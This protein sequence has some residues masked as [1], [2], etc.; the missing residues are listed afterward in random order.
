[1][2]ADT[3][4]ALLIFLVLFAVITVGAWLAA[5]TWLGTGSQGGRA[6][7]ALVHVEGTIVGS[8]GGGS[9]LTGESLASSVTL[10][11]RLYRARDDSSVKAVVVRINSPGGSAAASDEIYRAIEDLCETKKVVVSMGDV[12]A[13]GGYYIAA[14]A[15]H[16]VANGATLTGSI[17]VIFSLI[18]WEEAAAKLGIE[19][20]T[21]TAGQHKDI[22]SPW[23]EMTENE[24][25]LLSELMTEVHE[26][27]IAAVAAGRENLTEDEVREI[28]TG[29]IFTG[30]RALALGLVDELG[31]LRQAEDRARE[32][33]GLPE[34]TPVEQ[35]REQSL[36]DELFAIK[37]G[38]GADYLQRLSIDPLTGLA[39]SLF[40]SSVLRDLQVR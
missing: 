34:D 32:L 15:D 8:A 38:G 22:G 23:R 39:R 4:R 36:L 31:G 37:F 5:P 16:V 1:M 25:A 21:L 18:N 30:E 6:R 28:A 26:Q 11:D 17:G 19:D 9:L 20:V 35:Y 24:R 27:F 2:N 13:S 33:A 7:V 12:A 3:V 10:C 29:M 40:L 14:A